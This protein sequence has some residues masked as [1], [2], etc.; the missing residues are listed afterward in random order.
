LTG[1]RS[2][3]PAAGS[4]W[5]VGPVM[6]GPR[7]PDAARGGGAGGARRRAVT[8]R[9]DITGD[10]LKGAP[11]TKLHGTRTKRKR[12]VRGTHR[13]PWKGGRGAGGGYQRRGAEVRLRFLGAAV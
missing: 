13:R 4:I 1:M 10:G 11:C 12:R 6:D 3:D 7:A 2:F 8:P 9:W 5:T